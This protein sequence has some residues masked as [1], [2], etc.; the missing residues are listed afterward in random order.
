MLENKN[1]G[2]EHINKTYWKL[3]IKI[4]KKIFFKIKDKVRD[5]AYKREM[6]NLETI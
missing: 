2:K 1:K 3:T 6:D 4:K 5:N